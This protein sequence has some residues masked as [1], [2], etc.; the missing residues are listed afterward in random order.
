M[1]VP[2]LVSTT[3][4]VPPRCAVS[5]PAPSVTQSRPAII[6]APRGERSDSEPTHDV[7]RAGVEPGDG[8]GELVRHPDTVGRRGHVGGP[9]P[10]L[11]ERPL[12]GRRR[13]QA[14]DRPV[15]AV[16]HPHRRPAGCQ[17][18]RA[19]THRDRAGHVAGPG[20]DAGH[21]RVPG[22]RHQK[23]APGDGQVRGGV[24]HRDRGDDPSAA[25][26]QAPH[27]VVVPVRHPDIARSDGDRRRSVAHLDRADDVVRRRIDL[28]DGPVAAVRHPDETGADRHRLRAGSHVDRLG[29]GTGP[30]IDAAHGGVLA[31]RHPYRAGARG[32][33]RRV[34]THGHHVLDPTRCGMD[35]GH[36]GRGE[37]RRCGIRSAVEA[38]RAGPS[39]DQRESH[40]RDGQLPASREAQRPPPVASHV[41]C[42]GGHHVHGSLGVPRTWLA[43]CRPA[44]ARG[45]LAARG[46]LGGSAAAPARGRRPARLPSTARARW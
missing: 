16:G 27:R 36:R 26:V 17:R 18:H 8:A 14:G 23:S 43:R 41:S 12:G 19:V 40:G 28:R 3:R 20:V 29:H 31:V 25:V 1:P 44:P 5:G 45:T 24:A 15:Q 4:R 7:A 38:D 37:Q 33:P 32:D 35:H 11:L 21:G 39:S 10:G 2:T 34:C 6:A 42:R 30:W 46:P 22:V 9:V 13:V